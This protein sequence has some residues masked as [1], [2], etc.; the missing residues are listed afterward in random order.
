MNCAVLLFG[1]WSLFVMMNLVRPWPSSTIALF[2]SFLIR[3]KF[4][5]LFTL[6]VCVVVIT[7]VSN[8][9][10]FFSF[11]IIIF[12]CWLA[13]PILIRLGVSFSFTDI[14]RGRQARGRV[15]PNKNWIQNYLLL[16]GDWLRRVSHVS[17]WMMSLDL[18]LIFISLGSQRQGSRNPLK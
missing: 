8:V 11:I 7:T 6:R 10:F 14:R 2:I 9:Q 12:Y 1:V 4:V 15:Y 17:V 16:W 3:D 5:F 13:R 18:V